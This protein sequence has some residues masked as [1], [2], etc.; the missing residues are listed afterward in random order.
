MKGESF[1]KLSYEDQVQLIDNSDIWRDYDSRVFLGFP[2]L[3]Q[4]GLM[5]PR[6]SHGNF[7][8]FPGEHRA[9]P[10]GDGGHLPAQAAGQRHLQGHLSHPEP[11]LRL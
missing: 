10:P 11:L 8:V 5:L 2:S 1:H 6:D 9:H 7:P 3:L 4:K